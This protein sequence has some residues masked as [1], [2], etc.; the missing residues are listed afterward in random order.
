MAR[1]GLTDVTGAPLRYT[2]HDFRRIFVTEAVAAGLPVHI[3]A[4]V[5]G[6]HH[7]TTTQAY[8][9]VFQDDLIRAYQA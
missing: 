7:L 5:L 3:A 8:L 6:H 9:A 2:A 1:T 4:R